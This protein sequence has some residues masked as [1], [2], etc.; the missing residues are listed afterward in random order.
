MHMYISKQK[1]VIKENFFKIYDVKKIKFNLTIFFIVLLFISALIRPAFNGYLYSIQKG[2][3]LNSIDSIYD[4]I[5]PLISSFIISFVFYEDF[6]NKT[7]EIIAFYNRDK[8]N[9][10]VFYR[11][12]FYV[13]V[14]CAGSFL[15][16]LI[17][18][19]NVSFL[20]LKNI[21]LSLRFIPNIIFL[22][23]I[24]LF[25]MSFTKSVEAAIFLVT[26][27][28]VTDLLSNAR[29]FNVF[30]LG[31]NANNFYYNVSPMYYIMNRIILV[32]LSIIFVYFSCRKIAR[33]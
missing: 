4:Y 15:C 9:Y 6:K 1:K 17:Y 29:I 12:I 5:F 26:A 22:T 25:I 18:Y 32:L 11:W 3:R 28:Y 24:M 27:Y 2:N 30:S 16:G 31:A 19:R 8:F 20:D 10:I 23:S 13:G 21:L 33:I 14:L 7:Y